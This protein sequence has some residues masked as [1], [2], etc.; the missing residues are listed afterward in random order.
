MSKELSKYLCSLKRKVVNII[1][2]Q[3]GTD[4]VSYCLLPNSISILC[5][6]KYEYEEKKLVHTWCVCFFFFFGYSGIEIIL[7]LKEF[8]CSN[9]W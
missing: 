1:N 8:M 3:K 6:Q 7:F 4:I 2:L 5:N 9:V